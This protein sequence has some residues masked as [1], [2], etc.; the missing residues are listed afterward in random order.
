MCIRDRCKPYQGYRVEWVRVNSLSLVLFDAHRYSV[1]CN[2]VLR[3][4]ELHI[5]ATEVKVIAEGKEV[6]IHPRS[7]DKQKTT[8]NPWHY[9]S[10]LERKPGALRNGEPFLHWPLPQ[11]VK[12]LQSHLL[13]QPKGDRAMVKLLSLI[14][15]Y[16]EEI[17]VKAAAI[18]LDNEIPTV[19]AVLNI[20]HRLTE[21]VI[22]SIISYDVPPVSYTQDVYKR[23]VLRMLSKPTF[24]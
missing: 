24:G 21:P 5:S 23:Q 7:F 15:D 13:K 9:L 3:N 19:E 11:P 12:T 8:Y 22:P 17:G 4:V 18:A 14:A 10:A 20:I 6:A 1:P 2:Y 16:G